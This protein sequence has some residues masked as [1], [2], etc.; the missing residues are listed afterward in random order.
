MWGT[1]WAPSTSTGTPRAWARRAI[2]L[3]GLTVP[4]AFDTWVTATMRVRGPMSRSKSARCTSPRSS[5][6]TTTSFAPFSAAR[7]CQG[8]M[9][10]WCSIPVTRISS[11][12]PTL[13][14]PQAWATR[15]TPSVVAA[16]EDHL[17]RLGA[18]EAGDLLPRPLEGRRGPLGQVVDPAVHVGVVPVVEAGHRVDDGL[19]L[20]GGGAAVEEGEALPVRPLGQDRELPA[21]RLHV[22]AHAASRMASPP[23][24]RAATSRPSRSRSAGRATRSTISRAKA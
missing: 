12:G 23:G 6:G 13:A 1:A 5:T 2:S 16:G 17:A 24:R 19:R 3:T 15:F 14:R 10:E 8:T 9:L 7:I 18:D 4:S 20:L 11:P 22:E 21:H